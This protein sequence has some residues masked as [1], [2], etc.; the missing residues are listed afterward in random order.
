MNARKLGVAVALVAGVGASAAAQALVTSSGV[1]TSTR[2]YLIGPGST[3]TYHPATRFVFSVGDDPASGSPS[4]ETRGL[5]GSF[6][7][8]VSRYWWDYDLVVAGQPGVGRYEQFGL[9]LKNP[10]LAGVEDWTGFGLPS[11][12]IA[13]TGAQLNELNGNNG[14]C[15]FPSGPDT[16][17]SGFVNGALASVTGS[18]DGENLVLTG[19]IPLDSFGDARYEYQIEAVATPL[20]T[21]AWLLAGALGVLGF[22]RRQNPRGRGAASGG[23]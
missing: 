3:V 23:R 13:I 15:T 11:Y 12:F 4:P 20:P 8:D 18:R 1:E 14:P 19:L 16:Y 22:G 9:Q 21:T 17:C 2:H 5:S 10:Q 7:A 6:D